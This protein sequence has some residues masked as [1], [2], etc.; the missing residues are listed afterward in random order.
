M[1]SGFL[2]I[3]EFFINI[4]DDII[5]LYF[6]FFSLYENLSIYE[7]GLVFGKICKMLV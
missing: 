3:I 1:F 4:A 6:A 5:V 7:T 2:L